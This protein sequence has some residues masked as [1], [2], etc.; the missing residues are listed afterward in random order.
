[1]L[2]ADPFIDAQ[3]HKSTKTALVMAT[4]TVILAL[5]AFWVMS[6]MW[7]QETVLMQP[8]LAILSVMLVNYLISR[9][10]GL[11]LLEMWRFRSLLK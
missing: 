4:E 3:I 5:I 11:R 9:Y 10:K 6:S 8:E 7:L 2:L 1:V